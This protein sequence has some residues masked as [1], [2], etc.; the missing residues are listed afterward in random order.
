MRNYSPNN[1]KRWRTVDV[2]D[3][4]PEITAAINTNAC[5]WKYERKEERN[6]R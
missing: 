6:S 5:M 4:D 1:I 3:V 2:G